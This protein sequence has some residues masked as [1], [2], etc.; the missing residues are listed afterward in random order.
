MSKSTCSI[1]GCG[2]NV[3]S[4]GMCQPHYKRFMA[5]GDPLRPCMGCGLDLTNRGLGAASYC[6][7]G[8]KPKCRIE[9]C[10]KLVHAKHDVC[11][12][13]LNIIRRSG[14]ADPA[15]HFQSEKLCLV[16]GAEDWPTNHL[17]RYCSQRC[18]ALFYRAEGNVSREVPCV[19]CGEVI[20]LFKPSAVSGRKKRA[21][22]GRCSS[23]VRPKNAVDVS[24]LVGRD[25][26]SCSICGLEVDMSIGW[27][28][29]ES[30]SVDH[31]IPYYAGGQNTADNCALAH[32]VCNIRKN[33]FTGQTVA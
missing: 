6:D 11:R 1:D 16:C 2:H 12:S 3:G 15:W 14:G 26:T 4:R 21:D 30:P 27:P 5:T 20:D 9:W 10:R 22:V 24:F 28:H 23:C 7:D 33:K 29:G 19:C 8:C 25:G 17:R 32:L 13:H 31:V 18:A